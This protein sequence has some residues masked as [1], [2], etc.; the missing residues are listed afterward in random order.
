MNDEDR[1]DF[2]RRGAKLFHFE[3]SI[4][5]G[6]VLTAVVISVAGIGWGSG[7]NQRLAVHDSELQALKDEQRRE[8]DDSRAVRSEILG[9]IQDLTHKI[10]RLLEKAK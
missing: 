4:S 8:A 6:N 3:R 2:E 1:G 10:D 5:I 9:D 7:I